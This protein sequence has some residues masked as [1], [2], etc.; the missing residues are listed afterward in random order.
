MSLLN[1]NTQETV[2]VENRSLEKERTVRKSVKCSFRPQ[3]MVAAGMIRG[4]LP[5]AMLERKEI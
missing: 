5:G 2:D 1:N 3:T 4:M